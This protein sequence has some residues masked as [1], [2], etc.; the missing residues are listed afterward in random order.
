[1]SS[2]VL[3][4]VAVFGEPE[5]LIHRAEGM[6][7]LRTEMIAR[8]THISLAASNYSSSSEVSSKGSNLVAPSKSPFQ[9]PVQKALLRLFLRYV[10]KCSST[11]SAQPGSKG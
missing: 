11:L 6:H 5:A 10:D 3:T 9:N 8:S 7:F 1:M 2:A 4:A